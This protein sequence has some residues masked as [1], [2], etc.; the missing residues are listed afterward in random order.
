M[1]PARLL[2]LPPPDG[3][4]HVLPDTAD[5]YMGPGISRTLAERLYAD[6]DYNLRD[7]LKQETELFIESTI[8][9]DRSIL[10]LLR[11]DYTYLNERLARHYGFVPRACRPYRAK[12]KGKVER[13]FRYIREDFFLA[14]SFRN[15]D[16]LNA[17]FRAG[18]SDRY[19]T[20]VHNLLGLAHEADTDDVP[21]AV[22]E[23]RKARV[24]A[25]QEKISKRKLKAF[26]GK[27]VDVLVEELRRPDGT[28]ALILDLRG[29][30]GGF[31]TAARDIASQFLASGTIF[32]QEDASGTQ[33]S[34][35]AAVEIRIVA[36]TRC[37][38][39]R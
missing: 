22:K 1:K 25:Q 31:V 20:W 5:P 28:R 29:N 6:F 7:A 30:P 33:I 15:L 13:P 14:R 36:E 24:M 39:T 3:A 11:A 2:S 34:T 17:Q 38:A 12:T 9:E 10:D 35:D 21:A 37:G 4:P 18:G 23:E 26:V 16:D 19:L 27:T 8:R 32:W